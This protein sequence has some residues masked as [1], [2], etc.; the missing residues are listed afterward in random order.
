[1]R[2]FFS[3]AGMMISSAFWGA[4]ADKYGRKP[5]LIWTSVFLFYFGLLTAF[6]PSFEWVLFLRFLVG[7]FIGGVPQV[8]I[9]K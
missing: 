3:I 5:T 6:S 1:M 9:K 7:F 2:F 8:S 4:L